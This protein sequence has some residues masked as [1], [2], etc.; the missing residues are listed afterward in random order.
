MV[1]P[2]FFVKNT[3]L[4]LQKTDA[5]VGLCPFA[6]SIAEVAAADALHER[7]VTGAC[8]RALAGSSD[9]A[10][11]SPNLIHLTERVSRHVSTGSLG[12]VPAA[13]YR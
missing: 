5:A 11:V 4:K 10:L 2:A 6:I 9:S 3:T 12:N 7:T 8:S 13:P 1:V